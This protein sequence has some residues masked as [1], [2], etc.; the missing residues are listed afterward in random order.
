MSAL[1]DTSLKRVFKL[2]F[3]A[4]LL[5]IT[6]LIKQQFSNYKQCID[7][8]QCLNIG[9]PPCQYDRRKGI[10]SDKSFTAGI[11]F[12]WIPDVEL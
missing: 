7:S 3:N 6:G 2:L 4:Q 1:P 8:Q 5:K 12:D 10:M 9:Y 11:L